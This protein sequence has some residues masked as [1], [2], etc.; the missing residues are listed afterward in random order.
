M[1]GFGIWPRKSPAKGPARRGAGNK[2]GS[3]V[4]DLGEVV[5]FSFW[6]AVHRMR[7]STRSAELIIGSV[8]LRL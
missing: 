4:K 2:G 7:F 6:V 3:L 1:P 8:N 5:N